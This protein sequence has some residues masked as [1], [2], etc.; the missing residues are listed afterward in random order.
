MP[1]QQW[2]NEKFNDITKIK[3]KINNN[4]DLLGRDFKY[5]KIEIDN[6]YPKY[7]RK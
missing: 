7:I 6:S 4:E 3:E 5:R 1:E 2:N